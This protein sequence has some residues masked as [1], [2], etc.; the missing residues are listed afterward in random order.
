M[1]PEDFARWEAARKELFAGTGERLA[2]EV[3][4][5]VR[6]E[7]RWHSL[8]AICRRDDT[9]K[10]IRWTGSTTDITERKRAEE[11]LKT[12][13]RKL[14][15]AQ[16]LEAMGTLAGG[17]AHDF[18]NIL[19][20]ILGYG[21]MALRDAPKGSRLAR[22]LDSI[23]VAGE[24][25][26]A[27][28]ERVLAF[29]RSAVGERVPVHVEGV[30]REVLDLVSAKLPSNVTVHAEAARGA[31]RGTR[32]RDTGAPGGGQSCDQC[33]PGNAGRRNAAR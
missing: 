8:Q 28:V 15:Q 14:R 25:G 11:E 12:M 24:R 9:G 32:R 20:A 3:R 23:M 19:G 21:E 26:R 1:H 31:R 16:R 18:N 17:I 27:L 7:T 29:S 33:H 13:E 5:I 2:M 30:V 22:D 4:Y 10:V 6:G